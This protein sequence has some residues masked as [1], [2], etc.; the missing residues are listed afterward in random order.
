MIG[1]NP[2]ES[3]MWFRRKLPTFT[4]VFILLVGQEDENTA[5]QVHKINEKV[6]T[7]PNVVIIPH[8]SFFNNELCVVKNETA[9]NNK[10]QNEN[11]LVSDLNAKEQIGNAHE[12]EETETVKKE[13][14][15]EKVLLLV[16]KQRT[17]RETDENH[18]SGHQR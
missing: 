13:S 6:H 12:Q 7:V 18:K 4:S 5:E 17:H 9:H 10:T 11:G 3:S 14:T 1:T 15:E 16:A 2:L 8:T